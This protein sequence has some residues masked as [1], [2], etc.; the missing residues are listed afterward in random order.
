M[1]QRTYKLQRDGVFKRGIRIP[2]L[3]TRKE[4]RRWNK[5]ARKCGYRD[6]R[7]MIAD[8]VKP[9]ILDELFE[10]MNEVAES[11]GWDDDWDGWKKDDDEKDYVD[12]ETGKKYD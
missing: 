11:E 2:A 7:R 5:R 10:L 4:Y 8:Y 6:I 3:F 9:C 12:D 1:A